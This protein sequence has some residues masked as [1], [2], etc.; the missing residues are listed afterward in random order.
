[1]QNEQ[2]AQLPRAVRWP[3]VREAT[4]AAWNA[5]VG[6]P[7]AR[8]LTVPVGDGRVLRCDMS[9]RTQRTMA[10][11]AF[12]PR[13]TGVVRSLLRPGDTFVDVG[14]H[15]GWFTTL[16]GRVVGPGG[17]VW[18]AEPFASSH[19]SLEENIAL[20]RLDNVRVTPHAVSDHGQPLQIGVQEGSD[21][22][23]VTAG[24]RA[25]GSLTAVSSVRLDDVV[26]TEAPVRL[27]K[28]DV[29]GFE[30][31][32]LAGATAVLSRTDHVLVELNESALEANGTTGAAI[33]S[34]LRALGFGN[35]ELVLPPLRHRLLPA[36]R[37]RN[38]LATR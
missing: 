28:I 26:P 4:T 29:E 20:N 9:D 24:P 7:S 5:G 23:S 19:A 2:F 22:G 35:Q 18:A 14:A 16:A 10:L 34:A 15:I 27:V 1:M 32:V 12:E 25:A 21:S 30:A 31:K 3:V 17:T 13:E 37:V 33:R 36:M 8:H 6:R 38:L 11:G